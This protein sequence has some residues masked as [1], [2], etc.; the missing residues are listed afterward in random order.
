MSKRNNALKSAIA[1]V[2]IKHQELADEV[3]VKENDISLFITGRKEPS[4]AIAQRIAK[5]LDTKKEKLFPEL[6][7]NGAEEVEK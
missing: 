7:L 1:W 4:P 2:G 3:G 5:V 6:F